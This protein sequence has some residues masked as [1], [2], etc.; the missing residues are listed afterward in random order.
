MLLTAV[1]LLF[2]DIVVSE[3]VVTPTVWD[4]TIS[5]KILLIAKT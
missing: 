4:S 1:F 2:S 3:L 5:D